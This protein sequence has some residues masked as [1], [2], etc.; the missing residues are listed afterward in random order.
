MALVGL[1]SDTH[2]LVRPEIFEAFRQCSLILHAGDVGKALVLEVLREICPVVAVRGN[3]DRGDWARS[4]PSTQLI[5]VENLW[6]YV[7]HDVTA[8]DLNPGPVD[9]RMV[10]FGHSH[11]PASYRKKGVTYFNPGS[12]GPKR[13]KLPVTAATMEVHGDSFE[14]EWIC[15][16]PA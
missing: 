2:G 13:F 9:I 8:L 10:L 15:L 11:E 5:Q 1:I 12:A 7:L 3:V 6:I 16:E 4:L 14:T